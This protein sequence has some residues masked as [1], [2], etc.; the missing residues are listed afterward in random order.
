MI[1]D[2]VQDVQTFS[3]MKKMLPAL[4]PP[5]QA[6]GVDI[7]ALEQPVDDIEQLEKEVEKLATLP[8][9]FNDHFIQRGWICTGN[10]DIS[11]AKKSI[12]I[13]DQEE[14]ER[15]ERVLANC[16]N[17]DEINRQLNWLKAVD[18]FIKKKAEV[19]EED[20][21]VVSRGT[22]SRYELAPKALGDHKAGRYHACVPVVLALADGLAQQVY[23]DVHGQGGALSAKSANHE[24]WNSIV[25][26]SK[27]L[28]KL[29]PSS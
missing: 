7:D 23:V 14:Y 22:E 5:L 26:H 29:K 2:L 25:G 17:V 13:A 24:A 4:S 3:E 27:G 28:E 20:N 21:K 19:V 1:R 15:A 11:I 9:R 10:T 12:E 6:A 8:D 18:R 16:Y